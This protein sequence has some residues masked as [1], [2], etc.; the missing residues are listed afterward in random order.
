[1]KAAGH[2]RYGNRDGNTG[3][4]RKLLIRVTSITRTCGYF[5]V[6]PWLRFRIE[7]EHYRSPALRIPLEGG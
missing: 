3:A 6:V 4:A 5:T 1:M 7:P 2:R